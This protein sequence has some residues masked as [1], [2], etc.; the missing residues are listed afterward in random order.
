MGL[1]EQYLICKPDENAGRF[2]L[3]EIM[4]SGNF[5]K[6]DR[7]LNKDRYKSKKTLMLSW[8]KHNFRLLKYYP[9]D[10]FGT[11]VGILGI[12]LWRSCRYRKD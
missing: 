1:E 5:G 3:D 6:F 12:S 10:V 9:A 7:R 4:Q 11:P 2:L 8:M